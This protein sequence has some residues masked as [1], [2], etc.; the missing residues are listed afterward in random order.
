MKEPITYKSGT[1]CHIKVVCVEVDDGKWII[2]MCEDQEDIDYAHIQ[3]T[4]LGMKSK[5]TYMRIVIP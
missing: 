1:V 5:T 3:A 2:E 4:S